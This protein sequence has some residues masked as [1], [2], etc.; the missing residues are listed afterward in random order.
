MKVVDMHCDTISR[1]DEIGRTG[2]GF[3]ENDLH[4]DIQKL[5]KGDYFL[6]NFAIF[7]D[8][9]NCT[10]PYEK[11]KDLIAYY[12]VLMKQHTRDFMLIEKYADIEELKQNEKIGAFLTMEE[13]APLEGSVKNLHYF[14][15]QGVRMLTL[16]WN[17]PNEIGY[18]N[19]DCSIPWD[20]IDITKVN[21]KDGL[22]NKGVEIV[23][24][25]E[26]IGMIVDVSHGSD[27][28]FWEVLRNTKNPFVASHSNARAIC[29]AARNLT[30]EMIRALA[31]RGG[32]MGINFCTDFMKVNGN[33]MTLVEDVL[34][35]LNHIR[36]VGGIECIGWGSDYDGI[37]DKME[38][39]DAS[40]M[41]ML[42]DAMKK[43]DFTETE[44]EKIF[45]GNVLR[46]YREIL[47]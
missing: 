46:V 9:K 41:G 28:L 7:L 36:N 8:Q 21:T 24:E 33:N 38:W 23:R 20:Q 15:D 31:E 6:Q 2:V 18:P 14:Y 30:D 10:S 34:R 47:K 16:T 3:T 27:A 11:C 4:I 43:A 35:H 5:K 39:K 22:T 40:G 25:M 1:M 19:I 42:Y 17:Y 45:Y 12:H 32:V 13:G 29:N 26:D 37:G 44:I